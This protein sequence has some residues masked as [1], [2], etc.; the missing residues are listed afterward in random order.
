MQH[1]FAP[2]GP[3]SKSPGES[4][5]LSRDFHAL[6][7]RPWPIHAQRSHRAATAQLLVSHP[8]WPLWKPLNLSSSLPSSGH[9]RPAL[10]GVQ[11]RDTAPQREYGTRSAPG[12][13]LLRAALRP[14]ARGPC[15]GCGGSPRGIAGSWQ[16]PPDPARGVPASARPLGAPQPP[17][18]R[19][20]SLGARPVPEKSA[21]ATTS[22]PHIRTTQDRRRRSRPGS[23]CARRGCCPAS[24]SLMVRERAARRGGAAPPLHMVQPVPAGGAAPPSRRAPSGLPLPRAEEGGGEGGEG[25]RGRSSPASGRGGSGSSRRGHSGRG[26]GGEGT[27]RDA[28]SWRRRAGHCPRRTSCGRADSDPAA[29]RPPSRAL[30]TPLRAVRASLLV[31]RLDFTVSPLIL[32]WQWLEDCHGLN[33]HTATRV[34]T[35]LRLCFS[36]DRCKALPITPCPL[37]PNFPAFPTADVLAPPGRPSCR[38]CPYTSAHGSLREPSRELRLAGSLDEGF[39]WANSTDSSM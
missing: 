25:G 6:L 31:K 34:T 2:S 32:A 9:I 36:R 29:P 5:N 23:T 20:P 1:L 35:F 3:D 21:S 10:P 18:L 4:G 11:A 30:P 37:Q 38:S 7:V 26:G 28:G 12:N 39:Q 17:A 24:P 22:A 14:G 16:P 8:T 27:G 15:P 33:T 13:T 19:S